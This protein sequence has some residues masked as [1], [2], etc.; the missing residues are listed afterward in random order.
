MTKSASEEADG[1]KRI[2]AVTK[3]KAVTVNTV[4]PADD[5]LDNTKMT[6][7]SRDIQANQTAIM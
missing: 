4:Q 6:A 7:V 5:Q 1:L 3:S 2:G